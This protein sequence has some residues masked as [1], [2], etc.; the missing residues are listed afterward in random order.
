[1]VALILKDELQYS[2]QP[3]DWAFELFM[4]SLVAVS[5]QYICLR[6]RVIK[7]FIFVRPMTLCAH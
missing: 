2:K 7:L 3:T 6:G 4:I 5:V 1:M